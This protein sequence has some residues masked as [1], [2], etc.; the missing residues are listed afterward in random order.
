M[1]NMDIQLEN[2]SY[3][4]EGKTILKDINWQVRK[5]E[6]WILFGLNGSGKTTLLNLITGYFYPSKGKA[7]V[8]GYTFGKAP[9][10]ELRKHIG[11]VSS[12]LNEKIPSEDT[13]K[14]VIVSGLHAS[15]GLW[16]KIT[17]KEEIQAGLVLSRLGMK[18]LA[19]RKYRLLSQGEKQK[20]MIGRAL[21]QKPQIL[22]FD[23]VYNGLD[24]FARKIIEDIILT[25]SK[26]KETLIF[27]SHNTEDIPSTFN[28]VL[29]LKDGG[30][31]A[32]GLTR[33]LITKENLSAFYGDEVDVTWYQ[34]HFYISLTS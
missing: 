8:L 26:G 17:P 4:N 23:E 12:A 31:F 19:D 5:G 3:I 15:L 32:A 13:L 30:V 7:E 20:A 27:V 29:M 2:V 1:N 9:L 10:S 6:N 25:L 28:K 22:I 16:E 11:W 21:I 14:E 18:H 33:G 34:G 24:I